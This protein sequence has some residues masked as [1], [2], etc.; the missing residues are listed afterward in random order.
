MLLPLW[1]RSVTAQVTGDVFANLYSEIEQFFYE[2]S[3][4]IRLIAP[5]DRREPDVRARAWRHHSGSRFPR[6]RSHRRER[7]GS[8]RGWNLRDTLNLWPGRR[9]RRIEEIRFG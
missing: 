8:C 7:S 6:S 4:R 9:I 5:A 1:E 3:L 2:D